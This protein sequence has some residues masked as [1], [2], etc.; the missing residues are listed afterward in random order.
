MAK[1]LCV[2]GCGRKLTPGKTG[3]NFATAA[4]VVRVMMQDETFTEMVG[5]ENLDLALKAAE[6][7]DGHED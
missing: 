7:A 6:E 1:K 5:R 2:C 3:R 4:C